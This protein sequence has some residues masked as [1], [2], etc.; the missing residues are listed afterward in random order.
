MKNFFKVFIVLL[1]IKTFTPSLIM[2][3]GE[4]DSS[5]INKK[6]FIPMMT[7]IGVAYTATWVGLNELW[8]KN[9][10]RSSFHFFNDDFEWLQMDKFGHAT[11]SFQESR[12]GVDL[13]KWSGVKEKKAI[14]YGSLTGFLLQ[15]P[16]EIF[17]GLSS[18]YGAS[19]GDLTANASG[20]LLVM[21]QYLLWKELR[22]HMKYSFHQT[23]FSH[24]RQGIP[25]SSD[26]YVLGSNLM[27]QL[28]KDYNGQTY[29]FCGNIYSFMKKE[30]RFPKWLNL[31]VGYGVENMVFADT[32]KDISYGY[33]PYRQFYLS[34][35]IDLQ[36]IK[37]KSAFLRRVFYAVNLVHLP[38]PALEFNEHGL[39][40]H[41]IY[42]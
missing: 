30:S 29:W 14:I 17:D 3:E 10:P 26:K 41:P 38:A 33:K 7:T 18:E 13:L 24:I 2:A 31:A 9:S 35:D 36:K 39:K 37:T 34:V 19:P 6:R 4:R 16:I 20:S 8:Y 15:A 5:G 25:D 32:K 11:T 21:S 40:F 23:N 27:E 28:L 42:F 22:I 1:L 12:L